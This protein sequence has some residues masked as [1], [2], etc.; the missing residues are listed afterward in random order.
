MVLREADDHAEAALGVGVRGTDRQRRQ[1]EEEVRGS[2]E[3]LG[4][5]GRTVNGGEADYRCGRS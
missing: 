3:K 2:Q 1:E 4:G 5:H